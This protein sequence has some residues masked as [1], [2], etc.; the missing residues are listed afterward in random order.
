MQQGLLDEIDFMVENG[1]PPQTENEEDV[2]QIEG[3]AKDLK[4]LT[5]SIKADF[6]STS[7]EIRA[8]SND[9]SALTIRAERISTNSGWIIRIGSVVITATAL[10]LYA[11]NTQIGALGQKIAGLEGA[12]GSVIATEKA[13]EKADSPEE[14][15][16]NLNLLQAQIAKRVVSKSPL[17][18]VELTQA[19]VVIREVSQRYS[20]I[21]PVWNASS[22]LV[23]LRFDRTPP[24]SL[25]DCWTE[26]KGHHDDGVPPP[27]RPAPRNWIVIDEQ[28]MGNCQL[29]LDDGPQFRDSGFGRAYEKNI[30]NFP[31]AQ[32]LLNIHDAVVTYSGGPLI[33]FARLNCRNCIFRVKVND[34]PAMDGQRVVRD[35]LTEDTGVVL[36]SGPQSG[37]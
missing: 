12:G 24:A 36:I 5:Q 26:Y 11:F 4:E 25:P 34:P 22:Q 2:T 8:V 27:M 28:R 10:V 30:K 13:L 7:L 9:V 18:A 35:L 37:M 14:A 15:K 20:D 6:K 33:P 17:S 1:L 16:V 3:V 31:T 21:S 29:T 32:L 19:G 23:N